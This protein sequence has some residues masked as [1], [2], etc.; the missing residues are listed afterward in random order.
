M[1][2]QALLPES[3][4]EDGSSLLPVC[5]C[6]AAVYR[7]LCERYVYFESHMSRSLCS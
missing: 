2:L 4:M 3:E 7:Y 5:H 1:I 6:P